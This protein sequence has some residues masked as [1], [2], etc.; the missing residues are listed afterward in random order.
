[1]SKKPEE[2]PMICNANLLPACAGGHLSTDPERLIVRWLGTANIELYY[3][4]QIILVNAFIDRGPRHLPIGIVPEQINRVDAIFIGHGHYD[5]MSDAAA[6]AQKTGATVFAPI[7]A[8]EKIISQGASPNQVRLV[9]DGGIYPFNGFTIQAILARHGDFPPYA[10][11]ISDAYNSA[12][13]LTAE[14]AVLEKS[15][16]L[17]GS[18]DQA[19]ITLG[20]FAYLVTFDSGYRVIIRDSAGPISDFERAL[21]R[22][23]TKTN[24]A[25][26]SYQ[27]QVFAQKQIPETLPIVKLYNPKIYIP[28]HHDALVPFAPDM[29]VGPLFMA[30]RDELPATKSIF[31]LYLEPYCLDVRNYDDGV[32]EGR[33]AKP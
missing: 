23:I 10:S 25:I 13:P 30:I 16:M 27:A 29:G 4:G 3:R 28:I 17:K 18:W 9:T 21:M 14:A 2:N 11:K 6:I 33:N 32:S 20:T 1:M 5:H 22:Q 31:P 7:F 26:V 15:I 8:Y 24:V 12:V 19:I